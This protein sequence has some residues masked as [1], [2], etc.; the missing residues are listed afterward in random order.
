MFDR[1]SRPACAR[2]PPANPLQV[3]TRTLIEHSGEGVMFVGADDESYSCSGC[4]RP[5]LI[6]VS[7]AAFVA[8]FPNERGAVVHCICGAYSVLPE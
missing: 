6:K 2:L 3:D 8:M 5:I 7:V 1:A 4:D